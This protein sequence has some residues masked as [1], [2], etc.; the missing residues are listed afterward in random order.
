MTAAGPRC[1]KCGYLLFGDPPPARC[2]ECGHGV[3]RRARWVEGEL[4]LEGPS[5]VLPVF[6]RCLAA[7]LVLTV[8]CVGSLAV[9]PAWL[10]WLDIRVAWDPRWAMLPLALAA[11][12]ACFLWTR[13][14]EAP[15]ARLLG[16][17]RSSAWRA[18]LPVMQLLWLV[19]AGAVAWAIVGPPTAIAPAGSPPPHP[20]MADTPWM[21][22]ANA[23]GILA[24]LPWLLALRH[25]GRIGE[26]LRDA[27]MLRVA[28][29]ALWLWWVMVVGAP[30]IHLFRDRYMPGATLPLMLRDMFV[31]SRIALVLGT[32]LAWVLVWL[33][34]HCLTAA[35]ET[36]ARDQRRA[37][38][39]RDRYF[40][41]G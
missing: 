13:P 15:D 39:E 2:P 21:I 6:T 36:M 11:P 28:T 16:L 38:R 5:V 37:D 9:S 29:V 25:A 26:Y 22:V 41:P 23:T 10:G 24:Q 31:V 20:S 27:T 3:T 40:T 1:V 35:H 12:V 8:G 19:H 33:M 18:A 32:M 34:A 17:D 7:A 14:I 30:L 4:H